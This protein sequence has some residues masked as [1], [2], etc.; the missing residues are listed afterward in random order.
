MKKV[1]R[2]TENDLN[3][4]VR[5][6]L[7]EDDMV[8]NAKFVFP[9]DVI[10][11]QMTNNQLKNKL[12]VDKGTLLVWNS[13]KDLAIGKL[14]N[15]RVIIYD[16]TMN[17]PDVNDTCAIEFGVDRESFELQYKDCIFGIFGKNENHYLIAKKI[18]ET[19]DNLDKGKL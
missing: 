7:S 10:L 11:T 15:G 8:S 9:F 5:K 12:K 6:V 16:P 14:K 3:R 4:I 19:F 1:I 17:G 18:K 2:L 13:E